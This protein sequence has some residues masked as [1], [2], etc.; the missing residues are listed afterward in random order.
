VTKSSSLCLACY[1]FPSLFHDH[2]QG[3]ELASAISSRPTPFCEVEGDPAQYKLCTK[4]WT[5]ET[6]Q[7]SKNRGE[8]YQ[9]NKSGV[10]K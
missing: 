1:I 4:K 10:N 8:R 6:S 2:G 3:P 5:G 9:Y 7:E